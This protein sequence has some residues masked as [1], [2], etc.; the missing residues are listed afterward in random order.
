MEESTVERE[1]NRLNMDSGRL[2]M[3]IRLGQAKRGDGSKEEKEGMGKA[4]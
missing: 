3:A 4:D 2:N 1:S